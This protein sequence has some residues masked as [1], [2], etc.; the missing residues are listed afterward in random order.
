M[1]EQ[2]VKKPI[3]LEY[4]EVQN[5]L[6]AVIN[7]A[8]HE[9][10]IPCFMLVSPLQNILH[11]LQNGANAESAEAERVYNQQCAENETKTDGD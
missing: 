9:H 1:D 8:I 10:G 3:C 2:N 4:A 6:V 5:E 7:R 11:E